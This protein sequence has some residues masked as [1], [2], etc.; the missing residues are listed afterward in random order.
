MKQLVQHYQ[1]CGVVPRRAAIDKLRQQN[2]KLKE[3]LLLENKFSVRPSNAGATQLINKLQDEAD[4]FTRKVSTHTHGMLI[5]ARISKDA[6]K[7][8]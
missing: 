6:P 5:S 1:L 4:L 2:A 7:Q 3:E 8:L